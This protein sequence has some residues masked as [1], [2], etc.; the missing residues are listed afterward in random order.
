MKIP[1]VIGWKIFV[2]GIFLV[3]YVGDNKFL[4]IIYGDGKEDFVVAE[5]KEEALKL[6]KKRTKNSQI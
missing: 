6:A 5:S 3:N 2:I 1:I 4:P